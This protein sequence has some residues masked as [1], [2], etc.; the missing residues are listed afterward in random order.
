MKVVWR[1]M[2]WPVHAEGDEG[3]PTS[4]ALHSPRGHRLGQHTHTHAHDTQ[5]LRDTYRPVPPSGKKLIDATLV[6]SSISLTS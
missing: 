1:G 6:S 5:A 4:T 3:L 2:I